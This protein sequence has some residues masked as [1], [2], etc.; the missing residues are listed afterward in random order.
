MRTVNNPGSAYKMRSNSGSILEPV[1]LSASRELD[2]PSSITSSSARKF[3]VERRY[4]IGIEERGP[5]AVA[6]DALDQAGVPVLVQ[7]H[8]PSD[9]LK[10]SAT[11][12]ADVRLVTTVMRWRVEMGDVSKREGKCGSVALP[13]GR[14]AE[15]GECWEVAHESRKNGVHPGMPSCEFNFLNKWKESEAIAASHESHKR[16]LQRNAAEENGSAEREP[17]TAHEAAYAQ[18]VPVF[19]VDVLDDK[20]GELDWEMGDRHGGAEQENLEEMTPAQRA[21]LGGLRR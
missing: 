5:L 18:G 1:I 20:V 12:N 15:S 14:E 17:C 10:F 8:L 13:R 3:A 9:E 6:H 4:R 19:G 21:G 2:S 11:G 7:L 16:Q